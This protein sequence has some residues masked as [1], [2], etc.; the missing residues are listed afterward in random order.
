MWRASDGSLEKVLSSGTVHISS[1]SF[2]PNGKRVAAGGADGVVRL[3]TISDQDANCLAASPHVHPNDVHRNDDADNAA[4]ATS[5]AFTP[6]GQ[7]FT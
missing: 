2:S 3:W 5:V 1:A 7:N 6:D 4:C